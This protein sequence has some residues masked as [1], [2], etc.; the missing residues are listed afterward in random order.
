MFL[1]SSRRG[2]DR[3]A[4]HSG[5][6]I[7]EG[8]NSR[9]HGRGIKLRSPWRFFAVFDHPQGSWLWIRRRLPDLTFFKGHGNLVYFQA[10]GS[11]ER[12]YGQD[13]K[14]GENQKEVDFTRRNVIIENNNQ[15]NLNRRPWT[16]PPA[17]RGQLFIV[18]F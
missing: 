14:V 18:R 13:R 5:S 7:Y 11:G 8:K 2:R 16:W 6:E 9:L 10:Q 1:L 15:L 17:A 3:E 4:F 12:P